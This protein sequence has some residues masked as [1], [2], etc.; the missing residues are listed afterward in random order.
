MQQPATSLD[1]AIENFTAVVRKMYT[2]LAAYLQS[3]GFEAD[4]AVIHAELKRQSQARIDARR[5]RWGNRRASG[6]RG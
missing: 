3:A 4:R 5:V 2:D 6:W 1:E